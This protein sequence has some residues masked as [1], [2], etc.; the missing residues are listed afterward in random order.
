MRTIDWCCATR[1]S[2]LLRKIRL[3]SSIHRRRMPEKRNTLKHTNSVDNLTYVKFN[4]YPKQMNSNQQAM[5]TQLYSAW[6]VFRRLAFWVR[7]AF[8]MLFVV[9]SVMLCAALAVYSQW[10]FSAIPREVLQYAADATKYPAAPD[11]FL[12]VQTC[13]D[14]KPAV[15]PGAL[16]PPTVCKTHGMEQR[17]INGM[18]KEAGRFLWLAYVVAVFTAC[19]GASMLGMFERSRRAFLASILSTKS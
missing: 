10:S 14:A 4:R 7:W 11:G 1:G 2:F 12:S 6:T 5:L 15:A 9:P 16:T 19:F 13:T 18:A 17:S 3:E 8:Y